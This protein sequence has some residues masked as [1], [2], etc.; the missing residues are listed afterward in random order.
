MIDRGKLLPGTPTIENPSRR[1]R[2]DPYPWWNSGPDRGTPSGPNSYRP[3]GPVLFFA[4]TPGNKLPGYVHLVP[5]GQGPTSPE[6][7]T[8][9]PEHM[10]EKATPPWVS[11]E[12]SLP[13]RRPSASSVESPREAGRTR[14]QL[15]LE[16]APAS[17]GCS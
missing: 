15:G 14:T 7:T 1:A 12:D 3:Y 11:L 16:A 13:R 4:R 9:R 10:S 6:G 5:L 2:S 8:T 17:P